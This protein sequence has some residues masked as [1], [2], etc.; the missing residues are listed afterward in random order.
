MKLAKKHIVIGG[1]AIFAVI[2]V[3]LAIFA[4]S[5]LIGSA[6]GDL[7]CSQI[8]N[9][10]QCAMASSCPEDWNCLWNPNAD[11]C[12]CYRTCEEDSDCQ[13]NFKCILNEDVDKKICKPKDSPTTSKNTETETLS[14]QGDFEGQISSDC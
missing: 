11:A 14:L 10:A 8:T 6:P 3:V 2:A 9:R 5:K 7:K 1:V 4:P 12:A 13:D